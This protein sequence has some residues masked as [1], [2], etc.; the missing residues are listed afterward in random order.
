[1]SNCAARISVV[2]NLLNISS[3]NHQYILT[4]HVQYYYTATNT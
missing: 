2:F 4:Q 3:Y 1:M